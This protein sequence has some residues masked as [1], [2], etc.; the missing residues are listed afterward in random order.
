[1][2]AIGYDV[3]SSSI[4]VSLVNLATGQIEGLAQSP[5][6]EME[7]S[8]PQEGWAEQDP[9]MWWQHICTATQELLSKSSINSQEI[10][11]IG[12][13]YQMHGLVAVDQD[14]KTVRPSIIWCDS[15][16]VAIGE[17]AFAD[18]GATYCLSHY[19]NSPGNFTASK[20]SWVK[21]NEPEKYAQIDKV[22]LPGDYIAYRMT[23]DIQTTVTGLSEGIFWDFKEQQLSHRLIQQY[24]LDEEMV[25]PITD[26]F[27]IQSRLNSEAAKVLGL[28]PGTPITYRAG[29]QPNNAMT[30]NILNPGEIAATGGTSGVVYAVTDQPAYD[31]KS[32][33]NGFAHVNHHPDEPRIGILLC[34]NGAGIQYSWVK[35]NIAPNST[36]YLDMEQ[37]AATIPV[38]SDGLVITPFGNGAERMFENK[39][40]GAQWHH[41]DLNRHSQAHIYRA[42]LEGIAFAFCYGIDILKSMDITLEVM[43][44]GNDNLFQS[45]IFSQTIANLTGATIEMLE[46]TGASGAALAAG[47]GIGAFATVQEAQGRANVLTS[48]HPTTNLTSYRNAYKIWEHSLNSALLEHG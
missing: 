3:G 14:G 11:A 38:G 15:R 13:A 6:V 21:E 36:S 16:A 34:I 17:H 28:H 48:F 8:A 19:L 44:V 30:L 4:K 25:P 18:L 9:K 33:V 35:K 5:K 29:D 24:D 26:N 27:Q 2:Y 12:I 47:V 46:A 32:R 1:M 20:L 40:L 23:G 45:P 39:N 31:P 22:M 37:A 7:I 10:K 41:L 43:R 42:T